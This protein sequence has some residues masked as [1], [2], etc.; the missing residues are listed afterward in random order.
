ME[1]QSYFIVE[2]M[3]EGF[4]EW[5]CNEFI[6]M[7]KYLKRLAKNVLIFTNWNVALHS[8]SEEN[9]HFLAEFNSY[10][11]K[12][13]NKNVW[14]APKGLSDYMKEEGMVID[15]F[16]TFPPSSAPKSLM[17]DRGRICLLDM[18]GK[19]VL[20]ADDGQK[21]GAFIFGGILGDHPP[22]DRTSALRSEFVE[23][24]RLTQLQMSTDTAVLVT[25]I[26]LNDKIPLPQIPFIQEPE[27]NDPKDPETAV[28][29]EG[30]VY[31][32]DSYDMD[33][34]KIIKQEIEQPIMNP[35]IKNK[36]MFFDLDFHLD[37][38]GL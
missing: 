18:R 22:R 20:S 8:S 24:R 6:Q 17:V 5:T 15:F 29:M 4:S 33:S 1:K 12:E 25:D 28:Q 35:T 38:F 32:S 37:D 21:F 31:V 27:L 36:L 16:L 19:S 14:L 10:L 2:F 26:I 3:E 9:A 34:R 23:Q 30:F 11:Q 7:H 13:P